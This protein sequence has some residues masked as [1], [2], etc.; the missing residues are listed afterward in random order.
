VR[1]AGGRPRPD[2]LERLGI[3]HLADARPSRLSGGERQ[4]VALARAL[5]REPRVLLLDEPFAALDVITRARV[6]DELVLELAALALPTLLVTHAFEDASV[7]ATR[8]A[9]LKDGCLAQLG[10]PAELLVNP[11]SA[12]V[13]ALTGANVLSA[14]AKPSGDGAL[15]AFDAGGELASATL[16]EGRVAVAVHPWDLVLTDLATATLT[17]RVTRISP[18]AG[19]TQIRLTRFTVQTYDRTVPVSEGEIVGLSATPTAVRVFDADTLPA[20]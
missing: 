4:R 20:A 1:I 11:T 17:D 8:V 5:A 16:A 19:G 15:L 6:R 14:T 13:A 9:V 2:L 7:L 10:S 18:H 12:T 3:T